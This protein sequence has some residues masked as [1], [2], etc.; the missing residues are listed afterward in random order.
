MID[1]M[2]NVVRCYSYSRLIHFQAFKKAQYLPLR[3][4]EASKY[5]IF[6]YSIQSIFVSDIN[7]MR[8]LQYPQLS[9]QDF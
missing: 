1:C 4:L 5:V 8:H 2:I 7:Q 9:E 3:L 6:Q